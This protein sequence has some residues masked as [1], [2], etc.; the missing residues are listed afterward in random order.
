[1][2][3]LHHDI[4]TTDLNLHLLDFHSSSLIWMLKGQKSS[5]FYNQQLQTHNQ[6]LWNADCSRT[7]SCYRSTGNTK[8]QRSDT[9]PRGGAAVAHNVPFKDSCGICSCNLREIGSIFSNKNSWQVIRFLT[10]LMYGR[11]IQAR[12]PSRSLFCL[13]RKCFLA[14]IKF[15]SH[16]SIH[17]DTV[18]WSSNSFSSSSGWNFSVGTQS[19]PQLS[20]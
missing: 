20:C 15:V 2:T 18:F 3:L 17:T 19:E 8:K 13:K 14:L 12:S 9:L 7:Q 6:Q 10:L 11:H 5:S 16:C 1:M 4:T